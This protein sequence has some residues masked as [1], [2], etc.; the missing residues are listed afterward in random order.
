M[1]GNDEGFEPAPSVSKSG[2]AFY[3]EEPD[4]LGAAAIRGLGGTCFRLPFCVYSASNAAYDAA[5][6]L[7]SRVP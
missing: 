1:R 2:K 4:A 6:D 3:G 7:L 5:G